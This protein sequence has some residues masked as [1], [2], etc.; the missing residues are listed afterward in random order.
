MAHPIPITHTTPTTEGI[1]AKPAPVTGEATDTMPLDSSVPNTTT[2][3][4]SSGVVADEHEE[5]GKDQEKPVAA[6]SGP[7]ATPESRPCGAP[8][9]ACVECQLAKEGCVWPREV[10]AVDKRCG[11]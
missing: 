2:I 10:S 1:N 9:T 7:L 4:S 8:H 6:V 3:T 5:E 11:R